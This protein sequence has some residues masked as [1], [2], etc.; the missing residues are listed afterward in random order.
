MVAPA[1]GRNDA[2]A[3]RTMFQDRGF[4]QQVIGG[5]PGLP[6]PKT[7]H[8]SEKILLMALSNL[9]HNA[10]EY[11]Y[12]FHMQQQKQQQQQRQYTSPM[13]LREAPDRALES[14]GLSDP[15]FENLHQDYLAGAEERLSTDTGFVRHCLAPTSPLPCNLVG[16][17]MSEANGSGSLDSSEHSGSQVLDDDPGSEETDDPKKMKKNKRPPKGI[18]DRLNKRAKAAAEAAQALKASHTSSLSKSWGLSESS[19]ASATPGHAR[20]GTCGTFAAAEP[21]PPQLHSDYL[22]PPPGVWFMHRQKKIQNKRLE[23]I[24]TSS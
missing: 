23:V 18:R 1:C 2:L 4:W 17:C 9:N 7:L 24:C 22:A 11:T 3:L 13:S 14:H 15:C 16:G 19:L 6:E 10:A 12:S 5:P 8:M 21:V 20:S